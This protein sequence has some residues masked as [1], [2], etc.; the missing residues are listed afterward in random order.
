MIHSAQKSFQTNIL[1]FSE[2]Q[3]S[4]VVCLF[5]RRFWNENTRQRENQE[6]KIKQSASSIRAKG[7]QLSSLK[8][9]KNSNVIMWNYV[10]QISVTIL[11]DF[12]KLLV[13][14]FL[15]KVAKI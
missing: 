1:K 3:K 2:E 7:E 12:C 11:G 13:T 8:C 14:N 6:E 5:R 9:S 4:F 10:T 15:T